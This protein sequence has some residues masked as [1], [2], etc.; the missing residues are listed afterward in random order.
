RSWW[1]CRAKAHGT[2]RRD[3]RLDVDDWDDRPRR[4]GFLAGLAQAQHLD[5]VQRVEVDILVQRLGSRVVLLADA[6]PLVRRAQPDFDLQRA[7]EGL[8]GG[9]EPAVA[10]VLDHAPEH[11]V[12]SEAPESVQVRIDRNAQRFPIDLREQPAG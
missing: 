4:A 12:L 10:D 11:L 6:Q 3:A 5:R 7:E 1:R 2:P 9:V 8:P